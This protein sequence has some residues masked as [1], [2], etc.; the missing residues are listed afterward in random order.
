[1]ETNPIIKENFSRTVTL[2]NGLEGSKDYAKR[3]NLQKVKEVLAENKMFKADYDLR[4]NP[5]QNYVEITL[6]GKVWLFANG[7]C[8]TNV[9]VTDKLLLELMNF[10]YQTYARDCLE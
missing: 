10:F 8:K 1:M 4:K 7:T 6:H 5:R 3:I 2:Q 9:E